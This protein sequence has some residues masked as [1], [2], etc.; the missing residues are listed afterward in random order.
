MSPL[1]VGFVALKSSP[2]GG[3]GPTVWMQE[4]EQCRSNCREENIKEE[5][6]CFISPHPSLSSRRGLL[7]A[8]STLN[9]DISKCFCS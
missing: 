6:N 5:G 7:R 9:D 1:S 8:F 4:V 2:A 3:V